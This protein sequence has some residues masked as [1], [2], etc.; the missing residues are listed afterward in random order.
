MHRADSE[1]KPCDTHA[2]ETPTLSVLLDWI[3]GNQLVLH[4][5]VYWPSANWQTPNDLS[6]K[7]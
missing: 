4:F 1:L 2:I 7:T 6:S 3:E 5:Q